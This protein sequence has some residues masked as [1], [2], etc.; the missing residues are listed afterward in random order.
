[1]TVARENVPDTSARRSPILIDDAI[2]VMKVLRK[3]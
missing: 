3:L 1:M 2:Y